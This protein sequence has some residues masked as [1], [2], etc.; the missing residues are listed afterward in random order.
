MR[1]LTLII[2]V[3]IFASVAV[4]AMA[5][6][7]TPAIE[8][9]SE[10]VGT[11]QQAGPGGPNYGKQTPTPP[12]P[13]PTATAPTIEPGTVYRVYLP[14]VANRVAGNAPESVQFSTQPR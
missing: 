13:T 5:G 11:A 7:G 3:L 12:A 14:F 8:R 6:K 2:L 1:K 10:P 9:K 4:P